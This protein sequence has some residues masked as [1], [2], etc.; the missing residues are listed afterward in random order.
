MAC[1]RQMVN[2]CKHQNHFKRILHKIV[3][4]NH[5]IWFSI[6]F[7]LFSAKEKSSPVV[8]IADLRYI[9]LFLLTWALYSKPII[10]IVTIKKEIHHLKSI[11]HYRYGISKIKWAWPLGQSRT[12][13]QLYV[14]FQE[15]INCFRFLLHNGIK[16]KCS[17]VFSL[18]F[19]SSPFSTHLVQENVSYYGFL[20]L[21]TVG[22]I[23]SLFPGAWLYPH[24]I[25]TNIG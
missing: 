21:F 13:S 25:K 17:H 4:F 15:F 24:K 22:S 10:L 14:P 12:I 5:S 16:L 20:Q 1:S 18:F 3:V 8:V 9:L 2:A 23:S 11:W 19:S 6:K 7:W